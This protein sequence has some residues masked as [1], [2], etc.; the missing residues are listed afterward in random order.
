V[1]RTFGILMSDGGGG[2]AD[3]RAYIEVVTRAWALCQR[4]GHKMATTERENKNG[5]SNDRPFFA[6]SW[7]F[8]GAEDGIRTRDLLLGKEMLYH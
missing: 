1:E 2:M 3:V 5:P 4:D 7:A 8:L 6:R